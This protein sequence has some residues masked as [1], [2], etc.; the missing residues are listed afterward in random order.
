MLNT[1]LI[2]HLLEVTIAKVVLPYDSQLHH[3]FTHCMN[4]FIMFKIA[5]ITTK[6]CNILL[7]LD[8][9]VQHLVIVGAN[10][11]NCY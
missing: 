6:L 8:K 3:H 4:E 5:E 7:L 11:L 2:I 1:S 9:I 10:I